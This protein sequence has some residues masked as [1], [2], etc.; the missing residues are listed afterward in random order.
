MVALMLV[1]FK[2]QI[3]RTH[4][5]FVAEIRLNLVVAAAVEA[6]HAAVQFGRFGRQH[7]QRNIELLAA[8]FELVLF[9]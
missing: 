2:R 9:A 1:A 5:Q 4:V 3:E 6:L 7:I 8:P